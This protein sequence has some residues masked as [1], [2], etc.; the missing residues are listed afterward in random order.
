MLLVASLAAQTLIYLS[1]G[2]IGGFIAA[3]ETGKLLKENPLEGMGRL[4]MVAETFPVVAFMMLAVCIRRRGIILSSTAMIG[5]FIVLLAL[6][7]YFGGLKGSR[8]NTV[9]V[10]FWAVVVCHLLAAAGRLEDGGGRRRG[11]PAFMYGY[12]L[13]KGVRGAE[14]LGDLLEGRLTLGELEQ[15]SEKPLAK[16]LLQDLGRGDVQAL[17][18][19]RVATGA[20]SR[21][22]PHLPRRAREDRAARAVA[23]PAAQQAA[24]GLGAALRPGRAT[25]PATSSHYVHG[26]AGEAMINFGPLGGRSRRSWS[27]A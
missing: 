17:I 23:R 8:S 22:R 7:L 26:L 27:T 21:R 6:C 16:V 2:G 11:P 4:M 10:I 20:S 25:A 3:Y 24:R 19:Q 13:Y 18:L 5:A 15:R 12:G 14:G 1:F 9:W